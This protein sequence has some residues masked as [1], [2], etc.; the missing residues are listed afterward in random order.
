MGKVRSEIINMVKEFKGKAKEKYGIE[1]IILF[2]SHATGKIREG[3]D[4]DLL[5]VSNKFTHRPTFMS[6][7]FTEWHIVQ[8]KKLPVDFICFKRKEFQKLSKQVTIVKQALEEG[9]EI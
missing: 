3:S 7:L 8:K 1:K 4:I 9:I 5:I 6:N 2:G